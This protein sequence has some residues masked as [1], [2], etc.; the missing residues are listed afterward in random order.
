MVYAIAHINTASGSSNNSGGHVY[1]SGLPFTVANENTEGV[2]II[3]A[4]NGV[5]S[6]TSAPV[7][8]IQCHA[9]TTSA[10]FY[11]SNGSNYSDSHMSNSDQYIRVTF[12]YKTAS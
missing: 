6:S 2:G 8:V 3:A 1:I 12:I 11:H 4:G 10:Y 5:Q 9:N 7:P